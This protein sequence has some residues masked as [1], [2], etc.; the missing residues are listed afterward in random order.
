MAKKT[1]TYPND[2]PN[3]IQDISKKYIHDFIQGEIAKGNINEELLDKWIEAVK[4][5]EN[6]S[7]NDSPIKVF[8]A[9]RNSFVE[10]FLPQLLIKESTEKE[11][12]FYTTLKRISFKKAD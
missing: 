8:I 7:K 12:D 4:N 11:S 3:S 5:A 6:D 9:E 10:M 1:I 2:T